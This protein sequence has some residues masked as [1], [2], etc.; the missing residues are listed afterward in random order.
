MGIIKR[1]NLKAICDE[2]KLEFKFKSKMIKEEKVT[3]SVA[4]MYYKCPNCRHKYIVGYKDKEIQDNI[5]YIQTTVQVLKNRKDLTPMDADKY[6]KEFRELQE[7]NIELNNRYK[8]IY[9]R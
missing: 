4:R 2:C 9:G 7:R 6:S 1:S 5:N 8:A 3:D